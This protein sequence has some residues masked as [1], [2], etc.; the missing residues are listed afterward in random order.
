MPESPVPT[1]WAIICS[2]SPGQSVYLDQ[3]EYWDQLGMMDVRWICPRCGKE[4]WWDDE[5][6]EKMVDEMLGPE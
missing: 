2:C 3:Q 5:N 6:Y 4:A 1:P